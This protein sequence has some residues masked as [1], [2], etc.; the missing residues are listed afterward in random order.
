MPIEISQEGKLKK[1]S[2]QDITSEHSL[3]FINALKSTNKL[4]AL[5]RPTPSPI[6]K[7]G[8]A[9]GEQAINFSVLQSPI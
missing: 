4:I 6:S 7:Q 8:T 9:S 1:S 5:Y 2:Y 3:V